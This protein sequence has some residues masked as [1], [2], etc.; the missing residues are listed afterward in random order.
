MFGAERFLNYFAIPFW[1]SKHLN[2]W[3]II[4]GSKL[5]DLSTLLFRKAKDALKEDT[6][7][8]DILK[9]R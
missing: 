6:T 1:K 3:L 5:K 2:I 4:G 9:T 8:C 7:I